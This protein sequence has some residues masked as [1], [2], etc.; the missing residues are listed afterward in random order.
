MVKRLIKSLL[1]RAGYE[2]SP[3]LPPQTLREQNPD[4]TDIE[5]AIYS[6][7]KSLTMLSLERIVANLRAIEHVV[8]K[9]IPGDIVECGVWRGGSSMAM[10]MAL[11]R[12]SDT[13]RT[14]WMYDTFEGM[15]DPTD[16]DRSYGGIAAEALLVEAKQREVPERSLVLAYASLED[17]R[18]NMGATGYP[19]SHIQFV[20]GPVEQTIPGTA[21]DRIALL[22]IDTDWYESTRHELIHLYPKLSSDGIL[23]I[24][25]YGHWQGARRAVDEYF[26]GSRIFLNRIDY[27][28]RLGVKSPK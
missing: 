11:L 19:M 16:A 27:T 25:D 18:H 28:G 5:W 2:L 4:V 13:D 1:R 7:I 9:R 17:V 3:I 24:D 22:R 26:E 15:T 8:Q 14:L 12:R 10:A 20:K 6:E 23:I 21:P